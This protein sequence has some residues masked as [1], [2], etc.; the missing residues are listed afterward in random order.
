MRCHVFLDLDDTLFQTRPKCPPDVELSPAAFRRDDTPLSFMTPQQVR[1]LDL[2]SGSANVI[3]VTARNAD[4]F[5]RV[6][7][8][9][10]SLAVLDFGGVILMPDGSPDAAWDARIRPQA[11]G[12]ASELERWRDSLQ[13]FVEAHRLGA[14][15]RVIA[16]LDM[17][18]YLVLKHP[19]GDV[20]AL[21]RVRRDGLAGLDAARFFVHF[22]DNNLSIVP[23][24]LGKEQAVG[25]M[26]EHLLDNEPRLTIGVA[27]SD[28]D[29][30]FLA[31]C[32]FALLPRH[33]QLAQRLLDESGD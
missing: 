12:I 26:L 30:G 4:A 1:L 13:S 6:R 17:P 29:A 7:L 31:L 20:G 3:P 14:S 18:L 2:F 22:N 28:T 33:S 19:H 32:D 15:V 23:R 11:R 27:D 5:R 21:E 24:F 10:S 16:D 9:F 25:Y 8:R